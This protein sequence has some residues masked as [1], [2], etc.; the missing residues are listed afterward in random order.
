MRY[1]VIVC[2]KCGMARGVETAKKTTTCQCGREIRLGRI[3]FHFKTDSPAELAEA[4]RRANAA[5]RGGKQLSALRRRT[6]RGP[7]SEVADRAKLAKD[8]LSRLKTVAAGLTEIKSEFDME[9]LRRVA[10][11][12]EKESADEM[13]A[14]MIELSIV[15]ERGNGKYRVV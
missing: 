2:P 14:R 10:A 1:G 3:K 7:Y 8:P 15:Y 12:L 11:L 13:L 9:D 4:V 5:L 6:K